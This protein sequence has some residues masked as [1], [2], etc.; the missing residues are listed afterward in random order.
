MQDLRI[1]V[2][3]LADAVAA[4]LPYHGAVV[5]LGMGLDEV[6]DIT[7][8]DAGFYVFNADE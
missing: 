6:A 5:V 3:M 8:G 4:K 1:L 7:Q 2:K